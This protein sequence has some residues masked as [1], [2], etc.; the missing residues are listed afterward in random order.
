[1]SLFIHTCNFYM[2]EGVSSGQLF[3]K[4]IMESVVKKS[5]MLLSFAETALSICQLLLKPH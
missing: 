1:M 2:Q 4:A 5:Y 3:R